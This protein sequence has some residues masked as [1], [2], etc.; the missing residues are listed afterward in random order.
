MERLVASER[1]WIE[2]QAG[3]SVAAASQAVGVSHFTGYRWL[4]EAGGPDALGLARTRGRPWGG[5]KSEGSVMCFGPSCG[6]APR[7]P[8]LL[9]LPAWRARPVGLAHRGWRGAPPRD[10]SQSWKPLSSRDPARCPSP[11]DVGSRTWSRSA[12]AQ[13]DR[14][15][16]GPAP[17]HDHPR[18]HPRRPHDQTRYR[19]VIAQNRVDQNRRRAGRPAKLMLASRLFAK[20]VERL[21]QRHSPEQ[22]AGRL[23]RDFPDDPEMW[24]SH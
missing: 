7:S 5:R 18:A 13:R 6:A 20:V 17:V 14:L 4:A 12:T 9:G 10:Q 21:A 11:T 15:P 19:A 1:F 3:A 22:I 16:G 24:V 2:L 23:K 8:R